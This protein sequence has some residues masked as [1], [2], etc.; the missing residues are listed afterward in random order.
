MERLISTDL[1]ARFMCSELMRTLKFSAVHIMTLF[2]CKS[3]AVCFVTIPLFPSFSVFTCGMQWMRRSLFVNL[4]CILFVS[5]NNGWSVWRYTLKR[6]VNRPRFCYNV[7]TQKS[8]LLKVCNEKKCCNQ[9]VNCIFSGIE[10]G[11]PNHIW[12]AGTIRFSTLIIKM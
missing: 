3:S 11:W 7:K 1:M 8:W 2:I 6:Y 9:L 4:D 5:L 10:S 12:N